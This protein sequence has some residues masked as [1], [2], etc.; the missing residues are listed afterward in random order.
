MGAKLSMYYNSSLG[1]EEFLLDGPPDFIV[2]VFMATFAT[3]EYNEKMSCEQD[4]ALDAIAG[5]DD[6]LGLEE[7]QQ[8]RQKVS[9]WVRGSLECIQDVL[10]WYTMAAAHKAREPVRHMFG[11]LSKYAQQASQRVKSPYSKPC[12]SRELPVVDLVTARLKQIDDEFVAL[13]AAIPSW[14][15]KMFQT[16]QNMIC[17]NTENAISYEHLEA[18]MLKLVLLNHASFKRRIYSVFSQLLV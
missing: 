12:H 17:W 14:T 11:I 10:F 3:R 4:A 8:Y 18:M 5:C 16:L 15:R 6:E 7:A 1:S 13:R 2:R 9:K